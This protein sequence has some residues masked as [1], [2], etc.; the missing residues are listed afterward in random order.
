VISRVLADAVLVLHLAFVTFAV[1]GGFLVLRWPKLAW[2]HAPAVV[3]GIVITA[4]GGVCPLTPLEKYFIVRGGG[5]AYRGGFIAH[6]LTPVIYPEG[7]TR[8]TQVVLAL[9]L[10][11]FTVFVYWRVWQHYRRRTA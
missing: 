9:L 2:A 1:L 11:A 10:L 4:I 6:Y 7:M 3:W 8:E 5:E